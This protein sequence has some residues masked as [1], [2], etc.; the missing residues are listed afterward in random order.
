MK[1]AFITSECAGWVKTGGLGD[2]SAVL[3]AA[4]REMGEDVR[5]LIPG[6]RPV[7]AAIGGACPVA[8]SL[9]AWAGFPPSRLLEAM[10]THGTPAWVLDCPRYYDRDAGP[11]LDSDGRDFYDNAQRFGLLALAAARLAQGLIS[12]WRPDLVHCNDWQA[13]LAPTY[14]KRVLAGPVPCVQTVHNLAFQ[15]LFPADT[16][17]PL[18]LPATGFTA[19]GFEFYGKL[20]FLKAGLRDADAITTVSPTY[21][22]EIQ[23]E[24]LGF[25]LQALLASRADALHG[26][27]N[28]IDVDEWDPAHDRRIA[29]AY[30][31]ETLNP[32]AQNKRALQRL[33]G[34]D[35]RSDVALLGLVS[36][37]TTQKGI[38]I[39]LDAAPRLLERP[40]QIAVLGEGD[41]ALERA[42]EALAAAY[43][44]RFAVRIGFDETL[45]HAI[46]AGA[47]M[48]LM[49]SRF[50]PCGL[51]QMYSQRYGTP[52]VVRRTGGLADSVTDCTPQTLARGQ[53]TGFVFDGEDADA[54]LGAVERA[55]AAFADR[56]LWRALQRNGMRR[57]F[58]WAAAARRYVEVYEKVLSGRAG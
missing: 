43:P 38:D 52:P 5:I 21:A 17:A 11:Y 45:A 15:G 36:R 44:G 30:S 51:N 4:L 46:E 47:D 1:I 18:G 24:P 41:R 14:L 29:C 31:A 8:A 53:A 58:S 32:K 25:G 34:L 55:L 39:V 20:S 28:G 54:L 35:P 10:T 12:D 23:R 49:P 40:V 13:A 2:V 33:L 27:L 3:P 48:F 57:D 42:L 19:D 22:R 6:Y 50:E 7:L 16:L 26:I 9:D 56:V 37:I